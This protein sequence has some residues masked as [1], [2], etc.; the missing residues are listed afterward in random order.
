[1]SAPLLLAAF[2]TSVHRCDT[3]GDGKITEAEARIYAAQRK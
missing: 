3:N 2:T 1:M